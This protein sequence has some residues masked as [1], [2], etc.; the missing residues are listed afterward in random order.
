MQGTG[1]AITGLTTLADVTAVLFSNKFTGVF[2]SG[3]GVLAL[4]MVASASAGVNNL[5][6]VYIPG[7]QCPLVKD[8]PAINGI[9]DATIRNLYFTD[10]ITVTRLTSTGI[11]TS[12]LSKTA[13]YKIQARMNINRI[14][15]AATGTRT[16]ETYLEPVTT[17]GDYLALN[18]R[19]IKAGN[20]ITIQKEVVGAYENI[21][22]NSTGGS[23]SGID[24]I[25][26]NSSISHYTNITFSSTQFVSSGSAISLKEN[27]V[28]QRVSST[29]NLVNLT[30]QSGHAKNSGAGS[31]LQ[32]KKV[33]TGQGFNN[34]IEIDDC[35][36][37][38]VFLGAGL[39]VHMYLSP[40]GNV[41]TSTVYEG[42]ICYF[43]ASYANVGGA[44]L[45]IYTSGNWY[46]IAITGATAR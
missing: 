34:G 11:V 39:G 5:N 2:D 28:H 41:T 13:T 12:T 17:G 37:V 21:I 23:G 27:I 29:D 20:G 1:T 15:S 14:G 19:G 16:T 18:V 22:I 24:G 30:L 45:Y 46:K 40:L 26:I 7:P 43:S 44:G 8:S 6:N 32:I 38:G 42:S 25:Q 3:T 35:N 9:A 10:N 4:D 31:A 36:N 33:T